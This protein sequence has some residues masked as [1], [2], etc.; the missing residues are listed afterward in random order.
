MVD[1]FLPNESELL[2]KIAG[3]DQRAFTE[4]FEFYQ[5]YVYVYGKNLTRSEE[6]AAEIVQDIFLKI[7]LGRQKLEKVENFGAYLNRIVRN[8]SLNLIRQVAKQIKSN[9][10]LRIDAQKADEST[11]QQLDYNEAN[12]T[13]NQAIN[14]LPPQQRMVY[15]LCH[16][17]GMK[18]EEAAAKMNISI[19]TVQAHMGQA[20]KNIREHF[21][22]NA[23]AYPLLISVLFK[24]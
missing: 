24:S 4:L 23:L 1:K 18:Y 5:R 22:K 12:R 14:N 16:L 10:I 17:E 15:N 9:A 13:L 6:L 11:I 19:R 7:W 8:H 21:K 2:A 20:L 3:G